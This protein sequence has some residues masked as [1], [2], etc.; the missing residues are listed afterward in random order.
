MKAKFINEDFRGEFEGDTPADQG[1]R[2]ARRDNANRPIVLDTIADIPQQDPAQYSLD[3][4]LFE[5]SI[6][7][8]KLGLDGA[9]DWLRNQRS[10][11]ENLNEG[12]ATEEGRN[13]DRI[14]GWLGYDDL[15]EM[16]GDNPGLYEACVGWLDETFMD[17]FAHE[18]LNPEELEKVGLYGSAEEART[19]MADED[20]DDEEDPRMAHD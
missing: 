8:A 12:F 11:K 2:G 13:L 18:G 6:A 14:A 4:Q 16:L 19:V 20:V 17:Q 15:H 10:V 7:A 1:A 3:Q 5:L 9:V